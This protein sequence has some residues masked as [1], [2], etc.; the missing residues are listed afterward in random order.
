MEDQNNIGI[1]SALSEK[2]IEDIKNLLG[3]YSIEIKKIIVFEKNNIEEIKDF[4]AWIAP[5]FEILHG[6]N[7]LTLYLSFFF[8]QDSLNNGNFNNNDSWKKAH[9]EFLKIYVTIL[10]KANCLN[11]LIKMKRYVLLSQK[12]V[13]LKK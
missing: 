5:Y 10:E 9:A 12:I 11:S 3:E 1:F 7:A 4:L 2:Q 13:C 6:I 8:T